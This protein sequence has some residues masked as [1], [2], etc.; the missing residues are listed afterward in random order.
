MISKINKEFISVGEHIDFFQ[1]GVTPSNLL[2]QRVEAIQKHIVDNWEKGTE[3]L[4]EVLFF[5]QTCNKEFACNNLSVSD[6]GDTAGNSDT[7]DTIYNSDTSQ[8]SSY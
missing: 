8:W 1:H 7:N 3:G 5:I 6:I 4:R 2:K